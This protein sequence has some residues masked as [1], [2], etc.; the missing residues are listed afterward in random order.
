MSIS[1]LFET[2]YW[3]AAE[4]IDRDGFVDLINSLEFGLT[5]DPRSVGEPH[6]GFPGDRIWLV[7]SPPLRR[8]PRLCILYEIDDERGI[9]TLYN[10]KVLE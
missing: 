4:K 7:E 9:V 5:R 10:F 6:A 8:L 1:E 2:A 3:H